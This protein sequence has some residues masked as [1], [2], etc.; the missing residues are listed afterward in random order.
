MVDKH[1]NNKPPVGPPRTDIT[2][3]CI[4]Q[5]LILSQNSF[6]F[7]SS[8][9]SQKTLVLGA[10]ITACLHSLVFESMGR[11]SS[12]TRIRATPS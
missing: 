1:V 7:R 10:R 2:T 9:Y 3:S 4:T 8:S 6:V 11:A 5:Y 12:T